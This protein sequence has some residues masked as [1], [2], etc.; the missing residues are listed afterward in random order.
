[1]L[2]RPFKKD[3]SY[4]NYEYEFEFYSIIDWYAVFSPDDNL[5]NGEKQKKVKEW[6]DNHQVYYYNAPREYFNLHSAQMNAEANG[7]TKVLVEN[8]S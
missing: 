8:L 4:I 7:C 6:C 1:M 5:D 3:F 2:L